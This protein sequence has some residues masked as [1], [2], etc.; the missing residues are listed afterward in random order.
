M[1]SKRTVFTVD[2]HTMGEPL[3]LIVGG[4]PNLIGN[5][6]RRSGNTSS[7]TTTIYAGP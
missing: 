6:I 5:T 4:F 3:R 1:K 7:G 2:A